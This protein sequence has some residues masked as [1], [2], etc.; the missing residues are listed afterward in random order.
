MSCNLYGA[1]CCNCPKVDVFPARKAG[2]EIP[3]DNLSRIVKNNQNCTTRTFCDTKL[4]AA[5]GCSSCGVTR[6]Y[7]DWYSHRINNSYFSQ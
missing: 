2:V 3:D 1:K 7:N 5:S 6:K 4:A